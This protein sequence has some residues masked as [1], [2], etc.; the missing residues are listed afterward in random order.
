MEKS[1]HDI[2][3]IK[4]ISKMCP[5]NT[6]P[7][8]CP[9]PL[10]K[11]TP[12]RS[13]GWIHF[14]SSSSCTSGSFVFIVYI[15]LI[16]CSVCSLSV[17]PFLHSAIRDTFCFHYSGNGFAAFE[18]G[19]QGQ[20]AWPQWV[21]LPRPTPPPSLKEWLA[22]A[23]LLLWPSREGPRPFSV[24]SIPTLFFKSGCLNRIS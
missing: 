15:P 5:Y 8:N 17:L 10:G 9:P 1:L 18:S 7:C 21:C 4:I 20:K 13:P 23:S 11:D 14:H 16:C 6:V 3:A 22:R 12:N 2:H 24:R 19:T